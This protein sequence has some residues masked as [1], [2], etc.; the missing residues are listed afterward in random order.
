VERE[1]EPNRLLDLVDEA[2]ETGE[3]ADRRDRGAAVCDPEV[4]ETTCRGEDGVEVQHRL[5][6]PHEDAVVDRLRAPEVEGLVEDF[7]AR[8]VA[9]KGHLAGR[10]ERPGERATR[11]RGDAD[12]ASP[13]AIA[14]QHRLDGFAVRGAEER[15]DGAVARLRLALDSQGRERDPRGEGGAQVG[16]NVRHLVVAACSA[17][18]PAPDLVG[19]IRGLVAL[20]KEGI[21]SFE[22]HGATVARGDLRRIEPTA[23][24]ADR[25]GTAPKGS[26]PGHARGCGP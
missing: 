4:R 19:P 24:G 16:G 20:G 7:G 2:T 17:G 9:A 22:I 11:L 25:S 21:Q 23:G 26:V 14:H 1:G 5:A 6:H 13:V 15:L 8:Q 3:P 10:A 18:C 12:R